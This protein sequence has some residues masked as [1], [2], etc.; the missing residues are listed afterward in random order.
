MHKYISSPKDRREGRS[1]NPA[2]PQ[3]TRIA[4]IAR[5]HS[6]FTTLKVSL[7]KVVLRCIS[8]ATDIH[9]GERIIMNQVNLSA[10]YENYINYVMNKIGV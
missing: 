4:Y 2:I 10:L 7:K 1:D 8:I 6:C 3:T 5:A 9:S